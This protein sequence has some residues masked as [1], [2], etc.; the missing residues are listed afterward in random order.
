MATLNTMRAVL[1]DARMKEQA[2]RV[3][4]ELGL[5]HKDVQRLESRT[6]NLSKHFELASRDVEDIRI[7][8]KKA[9]SR[10]IKLDRF[11]FDDLKIGNEVE[12]DKL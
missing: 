4:S 10:A 5:L 9:S 1:K 7:S 6:T 12:L 11:E 3:R 8:A 2:G